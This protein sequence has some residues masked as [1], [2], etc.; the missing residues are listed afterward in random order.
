MRSSPPWLKVS[1]E[2]G[3]L[4]TSLVSIVE[5]IQ[6]TEAALVSE[7]TKG[8]FCPPLPALTTRQRWAVNHSS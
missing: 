8:G 1:S 7:N 3:R 6:Q 2:I 4:D 5:L